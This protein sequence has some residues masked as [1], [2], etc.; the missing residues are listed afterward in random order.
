MTAAGDSEESR[1]A[2]LRSEFPDAAPEEM[3]RFCR[4]RPNSSDEAAQMYRKHLYWRQGQ[5]AQANL[6]EAALLLPPK[7]IR[8]AGEALDGT[9][10]LFVQGARYDPDVDPEKYMLACGHAL[11]SMFAPDDDRKVTILI[12]ARPGEGWQNAPAA[13]ML[14]FFKMACSKLP[15]NYP[16][17]V[18][19]VVIYPVPGIVRQL[20]R[21]VSHLLDP[22]TRA[23]F[24]VLS[25][26]ASLD[27]P[28]PLELRDVVELDQLPVDAQKMHQ[29]LAKEAQ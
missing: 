23:K 11:D 19:Q 2:D 6:L 27:A 3:L 17:R 14:P 26:S 15:D 13:K 29:A 22:V 16:E 18:Q 8:Q 1:L 28:C 7:Y 24:E 21:M 9:P 10:I 5:G 20:W 4:A 25:G 12:D